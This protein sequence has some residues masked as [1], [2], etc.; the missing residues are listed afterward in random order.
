MSID[1]RQFLFRLIGG[2]SA[3]WVAAHLPPI[4]V[5]LVGLGRHGLQQLEIAAATPGI[6]V[7]GFCDV[8]SS[9]VEGALRLLGTSPQ[10]VLATQSLDEL[11][12]HSADAAI[13]ANVPAS[14]VES[15]MAACISARREV[16][17][18]P[19]TLLDHPRGDSLLLG[20][21]DHGDSVLLGSAQPGWPQED[22]AAFVQNIR[23]RGLNDGHVQVFGTPAQTVERRAAFF[24]LIAPHYRVHC[25]PDAPWTEHSQ[26]PSAAYTATL[27]GGGG[28][29]ICFWEVPYEGVHPPAGVSLL[30][31]NAGVVAE[32]WI[33]QHPLRHSSRIA[34]QALR[35]FIQMRSADPIEIRALQLT[36]AA[37]L[38]AAGIVA[39]V[40]EQTNLTDS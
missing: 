33:E 29:E 39:P 27:V 12:D 25:T 37:A 22:L 4:R 16:L 40:G 28:L 3:T 38:R 5:A 23:V 21:I 13:L 35:A 20:W 14:G 7:C 34:D 30:Y 18:N 11:L 15:V 19:R 9:A 31:R 2:A 32:A 1:R 8:S 10:S 6:D 17:L 24:D 36:Q 26:G